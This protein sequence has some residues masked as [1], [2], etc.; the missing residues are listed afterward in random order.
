LLVANPDP[1]H[2]GAHLLGAARALG[3]SVRLCDTRDAFVGPAW[4][5]RV[6]WWLRGHR[7]SA[8]RSFSERVVQTVRAE[9]VQCVLATGIAPLDAEALRALGRLGVKRVNF[10]TDDPWNEGHRA[11]WFLAAL[12]QYDHVFTPRRAN[13][14]DI[15]SLGGPA[16]SYLPFAY[17]PETHYPTPG[18]TA[19]DHGRFRADLV[20]AGGADADRVRV[21]TP[22]IE[23]GFDVA[24]YGGYW[25]RYSSTRA[26]ARGFLNGDELRRA[27]NGAK[28][29]LCLVRRA[30]RDG[31]S[32]RTF[33]VAAMGGCMLVE[34]TDE[35][36]QIFGTEPEAVVYFRS[37]EDGIPSLRAL[38]ADAGRRATL[39]TRV[40]EV[41]GH[42]DHTYA[43]RLRAMTDLSQAAEV[44]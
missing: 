38:L 6:N 32:M 44:A 27:I 10:L 4:Q 17:A 15:R 21:I 2:V 5:Q 7:P 30:N 40:R 3:M 22:F 43:A 28:V 20:F 31:H 34:D 24:L 37:P 41:I 36:R 33:E 12:R 39:S 19:E 25:E 42:G 26:H 23:A 11:P 8:L 9:G 35:H 14:T 13:M 18:L 1:V 29:S 16:V